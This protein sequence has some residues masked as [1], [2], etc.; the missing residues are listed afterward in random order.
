M[1]SDATGNDHDF[2]FESGHVALDLSLSGGTDWRSRWERLHTPRE[3]D[4]WLADCSLGV[5]GLTASR[6][7]LAN[8]HD[9]REGVWG[10]SQAIASDLPPP[11]SAIETVNRHAR[12]PVLRRRFTPDGAAVW[13]Q[14]T[15]TAALGTIANA[16]I[17]L[18]SRDRDQSGLRRC[19]GDRCYLVFID[20]SP[21]RRRRWCSMQ[22]CGNRHKVRT[23]RAKHSI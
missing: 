17:E 2:W 14:P 19:E 7:D 13:D 8:A 20:M 1:G 5:S 10:V 21:S 12:L 9:L 6:R 15:A 4:A 3:L 16:A 22:R 11:E 23:H 18:L